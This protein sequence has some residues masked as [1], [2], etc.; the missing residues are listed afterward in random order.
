MNG[1]RT[2]NT[3]IIYG[4]LCHTK[5]RLFIYS[6][7]AHPTY[8]HTHTRSLS[9]PFSHSF[10]LFR[11]HWLPVIVAMTIRKNCS[12]ARFDTHKHIVHFTMNKKKKIKIKIKMRAFIVACVHV[13][14]SQKGVRVCVCLQWRCTCFDLFRT[15]YSMYPTIY[16]IIIVVLYLFVHTPLTFWYA[17]FRF[18]FSLYCSAHFCVSVCCKQSTISTLSLIRT[19][20]RQQNGTKS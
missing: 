4:C 11:S 17:V 15:H 1:I 12:N 16:F 13:Y 9:V 14:K 3:Q 7:A 5:R 6:Y 8:K 19:N 20:G 18:F 2:T 10:A